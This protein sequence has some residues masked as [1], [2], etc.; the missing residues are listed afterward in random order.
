MKVTYQ[1]SEYSPENVTGRYVR[2]ATELDR[3]WA[4][5]AEQKHYQFK[6]FEA[7]TCLEKNS[8]FHGRPGMGYTLRE[9]LTDGSDLPAELK[10]ICLTEEH[11]QTH[12]WD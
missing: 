2:L 12:K 10:T 1:S 9:Y 7:A 3:E 6:I 11:R 8:P 4:G 5:I